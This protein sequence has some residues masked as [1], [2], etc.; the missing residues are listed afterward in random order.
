MTGVPPKIHTTLKM[1]PEA[2]V[3]SAITNGISVIAIADHHK[4]GKSKTAISYTKDKAILV[5]PA[6]ELSTN[7]G[8]LLVYTETIDQ[9]DAMAGKLE[10]SA[11]RKACKSTMKQAIDCVALHGGFAIA[12]HINKGKGFDKAIVDYGD[13]KKDV[14]EHP[15]LL[16]IEVSDKE[17]LSM[18]VCVQRGQFNFL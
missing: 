5:I 2:I 14:L 10:F 4:F 17:E 8:H 6:I 12:A 3:D 15:E 18:V 11:D 9:I 16:G 1:T 7:E 13:P